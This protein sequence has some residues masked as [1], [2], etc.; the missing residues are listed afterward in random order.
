MEATEHKY[1][2]M[3][4]H[5][6]HSLAVLAGVPQAGVQVAPIYVAYEVAQ[7]TLRPKGRNVCTSASISSLRF[8]S[9]SDNFVSGTSLRLVCCIFEFMC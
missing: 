1:Q 5:R 8:L 2:A 3:D 9:N 6:G 7:G 4:M